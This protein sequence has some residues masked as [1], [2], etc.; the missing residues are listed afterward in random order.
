ANAKGSKIYDVDG[1]EY[2]DYVL[3]WGPMILGHANPEVI[4]RLRE[5]LKNGTSFGAPTA[6][7]VELAQMIVKAFP[8]IEMVRMVN[9]GTEATMSAI[10]LARAYTK[11]DKILKFEG[12]YHGHVDSLLV[13]AGSGATTLGIPNSPGVLKDIAKNTITAPFN[14]IGYLEKI[15]KKRG[16]DIASIIVE[17]VPGNMGLILP[18]DDFLPCLRKLADKYEIILI[19]DEVISGFRVAY[20]GAQQLY[21]VRPDLTCLGKIIGGGLPVGA[22]GGRKDIMSMVAPLGEM[23]QAGTLSGN[24]LAISAGITTLKILSDSDI[25]K[26]LEYRCNILYEGLRD[27]ARS[28]ARDVTINHI[29]SALTIFFSKER[30]YDYSTAIK[31]D[32]RRF[33]KFFNVMLEQGIYLPPSQF[34]TLFLSTQH[35]N[36]DIKITI[37]AAY[38]AFKCL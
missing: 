18:E 14:N 10:R 35:S 8:S 37:N 24:P 25:Y 7:E 1:G 2:I 30:I 15:L 5:S 9:S 38:N 16:R 13:K 23:Y 33:A 12:C 34:E 32:T 3:S 4:K 21:D 6:L 20:G 28:L 19:F 26:N 29:G 17:P 27:A 36:R 22:Y 11:R 31:S